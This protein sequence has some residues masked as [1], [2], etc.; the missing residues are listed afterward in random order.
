MGRL[1]EIVLVRI[2]VQYYSVYYTVVSIKQ[3]PNCT[4]V[5]KFTLYTV[6]FV[7]LYEKHVIPNHCRNSLA[8]R[9]YIVSNLQNSQVE[10]CF[11]ALRNTPS[12]NVLSR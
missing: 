6:Q 10:V 9:N 3:C 4:V 12:K 7:I 11:C 5:I 1:Y 2:Q 8:R